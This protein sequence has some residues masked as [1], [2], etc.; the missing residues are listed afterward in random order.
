MG[1]RGGIHCSSF[2]LKTYGPKKSVVSTVV[3]L[4]ILANAGAA[5]AED[6]ATKSFKDST[7]L[8]LEQLVNI[9][10][11][12]VSKKEEK[13][14]DAA[15]A[16]SVLTGDDLHR[17]GATSV[18]EA[19][20]LV[21]GMDVGQVNAYTWAVSAR[22]F[23]GEFANKLLVMVDGRSVYT[24]LFS[25]VYWDLQQQML[26]DLDRIEVIR[27]PGGAIWGANAVNGVINIVS[28][29]AK[30]TQGSLVYGSGGDEHLTMDGGRYGGMIGT[31]TYYRVFGSYQKTDDYDL[32]TN[33]GSAMDGWWGAEG[34]FRVDQYRGSD[35]HLTW[36]ADATK[37]EIPGQDQ[38]G[39]NVNTIGRWTREFSDRSSIEVQA[40]YDRFYRDYL[41]G[42]SI[43]TLDLTAQHTFGLGE[44]NDIIWGVG[45]RFIGSSVD[46]IGPIIAITNGNYNQQIFSFFAQDE[47]K[48]IP[49]K[50]TITLGTK[51]EHNDVTGLEI[52]PSLSAVFKPAENQTV[53]ASISRAVRSPSDFEGRDLT[54]ITTGAPSSGPGGGLY[55]PQLVGNPGLDSEVLLAYEAGYRIQPAKRVNVDLAVFYND[56]SD[57]IAGGTSPV[58]VPGVPIGSVTTNLVN[59][60]KAQTYGG[61]LAVTVAP[62]D[63]WRLTASYSLLREHLDRGIFLT[64]NG[65]PENQV[66][67]RSAYDFTKRAS[68]DAQLRY[69]SGFTGVSSY[70]TADIRLSY[71]PTDNI[72]LSIVGQNL[73]QAQ[74][75]EQ[76][77]V[78]ETLVS[79]APR[80]FY[81]KVSWR[82]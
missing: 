82:F 50:L 44:R 63:D 70:V 46:S 8:D 47:F 29:S 17:S 49:G 52:Q 58:F 78:A 60:P 33:G 38:N 51:V 3:A 76:P 64:G 21:P 5:R 40:Y 55:L 39:Y 41:V 36:Q 42:D 11:T 10:V 73:L 26:D 15:A 71:R 18:A 37:S 32:A 28:K 19:L 57:L 62:T 67:L 80:G 59:G 75:L 34:G 54:R 48:I 14:T 56:Y 6:P 2:Y 74:H 31:N 69:V 81:G 27:G 12:S 4:A 77:I 61:E 23:N 68:F 24:P 45:Y 25:G 20:R 16:I 22:G 66:S 43:D 1:E 65:D 79:E 30:D 9:Q 35:T 7:D 53:W 72:E 13:L